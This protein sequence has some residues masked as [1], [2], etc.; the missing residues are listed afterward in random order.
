MGQDSAGLPFVAYLLS[1]LFGFERSLST[2]S[3]TTGMP[4]LFC[5][6]LKQMDEDGKVPGK[7]DEVGAPQEASNS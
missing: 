6:G 1:P 5:K 4:A 3:I 2:E 7:P